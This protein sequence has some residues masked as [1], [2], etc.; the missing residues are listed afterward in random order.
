MEN[1][2]AISCS[3]DVFLMII[4]KTKGGKVGLA[5]LKPIWRKDEISI[6][7]NK[8]TNKT[9]ALAINSYMCNCTLRRLQDVA[10]GLLLV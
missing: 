5:S 10:C 7:I 1:M 3:T 2:K 6:N 9:S 4:R 8:Q